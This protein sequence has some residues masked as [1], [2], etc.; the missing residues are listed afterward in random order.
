MTIA[1]IGYGKMGRAVEQ[2]AED[3]N[4]ENGLNHRVVHKFTVE[5][6]HEVTVENLSQVDVAIEFTTPETAYDNIRTCFEAG[7][8][9][10]SGTTGWNEKMEEI[11]ELCRQQEHAFFHAPNFSI[12][13]NILFALN[14]KLGEIM[15]QQDQYSAMIEETHHTEK[16]D[17]PSGTAVKLADQLTSTLQRIK[18]WEGF[19]EELPAESQ[20]N[21]QLPVLSKREA[22][23]PGT[24]VVSYTSDVDQLSIKHTAFSRKGFAMGAVL[25]AEW[26]LGKT[27]YFEMKDM[28]NF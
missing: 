18:N 24:H 3:R 1:I 10:V 13:V 21:E 15:N 14:K 8:P 27:G 17:A 20:P 22:N 7:I 25:A 5:N 9:V 4:A 16:K 12:G 23:V 19:E 6:R 28:L 11:K 26:M 2:A